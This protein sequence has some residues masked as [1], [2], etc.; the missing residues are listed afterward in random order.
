MKEVTIII[1]TLTFFVS[2]NIRQKSESNTVLCDSVKYVTLEDSVLKNFITEYINQ[3]STGKGGIFK[4][5]TSSD[6]LER[7]EYTIVKTTSVYSEDSIATLVYTKLNGYIV[8]FYSGIDKLYP[9]KERFNHFLKISQSIANNGMYCGLPGKLVFCGK[10]VDI[11]DYQFNKEFENE[12]SCVKRM[13]NE[14]FLP[15][16]VDMEENIEDEVK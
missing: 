10:K 15:P 13:K 16:K 1:I 11:I 2:C 7:K 8:L 12:I 3:N 9:S 4:V 6:Y 14:E 5:Q